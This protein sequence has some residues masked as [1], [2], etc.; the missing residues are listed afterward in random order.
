MAAQNLG[1][2]T[3]GIE[4]DPPIRIDDCH[5]NLWSLPGLLRREFLWDVGLRISLPDTDSQVSELHFLLPFGSDPSTK[6]VDLT[7]DLEHEEVARLIFGRPV[8]VGQGRIDYGK[9]PLVLTPIDPTGS[10]LDSKRSGRWYS[11]W[12]VQLQKPIAPGT[13]VYLRF[14]FKV[15]GL[16]RLWRW[17]RYL[18]VR[19]GA[20]VDIRFSDFRETTLVKAWKRY[21]TVLAPIENLYVFAIIPTRFVPS[22]ASPEP[23]YVRFLEGRSWNGY[24]K[25]KAG[26]LGRAKLTI[27]EWRRLPPRSPNP[28]PDSTKPVGTSVMDPLRILLDLRRE[29]PL[30]PLVATAVLAVVAAGLLLKVD[31]RVGWWRVVV[32][33]ALVVWGSS[34]L[35]IALA[36]LPYSNR[37]VAAAA[38]AVLRVDDFLYGA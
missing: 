34:G 15:R 19:S 7:A 24:T 18:G 23:H 27:L 30:A 26:R 1:M 35:A 14:R 21:E 36:A 38:R 33:G 4:A 3:F 28:E 11:R 13:V 37:F 16:G 22:S 12:V 25:R 29:R 20:L 32:A 10:E 8:S 9:G 17:K 2:G 31:F 6:P 5:I